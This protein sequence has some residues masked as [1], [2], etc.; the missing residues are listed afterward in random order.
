[1]V[2]YC[3]LTWISVIINEVEH[4]F[5]CLLVILVSSTVRDY[6]DFLNQFLSLSFK[7]SFI[8]DTF[9]VSYMC[10]IDV[11]T[12]MASAFFSR[13]VFSPFK[14]RSHLHFNV[15]TFFILF[16]Y[17]LYFWY[18]FDESFST[19]RS[20]KFSPISYFKTFIILPFP[21]RFLN[22]LNIIL[23]CGMRLVV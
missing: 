6:S 17:V 18:L 21:S 4:L 11:S 9:L 14:W 5:I 13:Y 1:M 3:I 23:V 20:Q 22:H 15:T 16:N 2:S 8:L 19:T 12:V 7:S 10:C